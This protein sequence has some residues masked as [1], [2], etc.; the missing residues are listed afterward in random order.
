MSSNV[1]G[2]EGEGFVNPSTAVPGVFLPPVLPGFATSVPA[3]VSFPS[4]PGIQG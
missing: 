2:D 1:P 3:A 4:Q